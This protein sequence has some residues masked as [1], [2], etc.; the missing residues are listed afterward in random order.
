MNT[1]IP[2]DNQPGKPERR[3]KRKH[4][5][6]A[7]DNLVSVEA[8]DEAGNQISQ[9]MGRALDVSQSGLKIETPHPLS[10]FENGSMSLVTV[11]LDDRLVKTS[12]KMVYSCRTEKGMY[13]TGIQLN[14]LEAVNR[15]FVVSLIKKYNHE[16]HTGRTIIA[17]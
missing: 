17:A 8:A 6:V 5:R 3:C 1:P 7:I 13:A 12:G 14:G 2:N 15:R 16:K 9:S 4:P 10:P 11:D